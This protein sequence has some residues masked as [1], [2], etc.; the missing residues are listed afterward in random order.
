ML[1]NNLK[2]DN[3]LCSCADP[4][5][6]SD[7]RVIDVSKAGGCE[8]TQYDARSSYL[9]R[10][11]FLAPEVRQKGLTSFASDVYSLCKILNAVLDREAA[12]TTLTAEPRE[13]AE[14]FLCRW[15]SLCRL[16]LGADPPTRPSTAHLKQF[17]SAFLSSPSP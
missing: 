8:G 3:I 15:D 1:I 7:I 6:C 9:R 11:L 5:D 10:F 2:E 17:F 12:L 14:R 4:S 13:E 16:C